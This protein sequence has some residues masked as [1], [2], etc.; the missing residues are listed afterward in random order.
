MDSSAWSWLL[1]RELTIG[2]ALAGGAASIAAMVLQL[3]RS[4]S[5]FWVRRLNLL[6]YAFM[7]VSIVLFIVR[8]VV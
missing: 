1:A 7:G 3:Q 8:G 5:P 4:A 6:A 2:F